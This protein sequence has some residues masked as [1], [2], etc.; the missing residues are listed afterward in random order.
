MNNVD[1][2]NDIYSLNSEL[3]DKEGVSLHQNALFGDQDNFG[4]Q[5]IRK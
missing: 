1:L 4:C 3:K 2:I 5:L